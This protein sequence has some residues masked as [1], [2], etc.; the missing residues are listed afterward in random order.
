MST[1]LS[2]TISFGI[3]MALAL[4]AF[5]VVKWW[6]LRVIGVTPVPLFT[7]IAILSRPGSMLG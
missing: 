4:V 3:V 6:N 7:F 2:L 1:I 5:C